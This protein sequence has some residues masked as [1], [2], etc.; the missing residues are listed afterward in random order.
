M[1]DGKVAFI[2]H[3]AATFARA[4]GGFK[5]FNSEIT[6]TH[7]WDMVRT[8]PDNNPNTDEP[9]NEAYGK[10][11]TVR[12]GPDGKVII[13]DPHFM[14]EQLRRLGRF[15]DEQIADFVDAAGYEDGDA[16]IDQ[17]RGW[18]D[19][20]DINGK[21][22][23]LLD[24]RIA[25][26]DNFTD[27]DERDLRWTEGA[28]QTM[29]AAIAA[30]GMR[31][32]MINTLRERRDNIVEYFGPLVE[33]AL[34]S[35][36]R[37]KKRKTREVMGDPEA[38][39]W[40]SVIPQLQDAKDKGKTIV[41]TNGHFVLFHPGHSVSLEQ[42]RDVA[43]ASR[44]DKNDENV[45]LLAIVNADHQ[46]QAKGAEK[47]A[48]QTAHERAIAVHNDMH[49]DHVVISEAPV[50]D[51]SLVTDF[52]KLADAGLITEDMI[53]VKGGDYDP[54]ANRPPE[55]DII[56]TN[57]GVFK[58]VDRVGSFSTSS[59]VDKILTAAREGGNL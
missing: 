57:G 28:K 55:A 29:E 15:T 38:F 23:A 36:E 37:P 1:K 52:Q 35:R 54:T 39:S 21:I 48:A 51:G 9:V 17:I 43:T 34:K 40:E 25:D 46:T 50:G 45:V 49:S 56:V 4:S 53:Y 31:S 44:S 8:I 33:S 18:I 6:N 58:I 47:G 16:S 10:I 13:K 12:G 24:K 27:K 26:G 20:K 42:A 5:E 30:G 22:A 14:Q 59:I 3:G 11:M 2:D 32:Y 41:V 7:I 19:S